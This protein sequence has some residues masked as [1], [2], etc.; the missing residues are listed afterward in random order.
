MTAGGKVRR[1][2]IYVDQAS[3]LGGSS[4]VL[5]GF[6]DRLFA[7]GVDPVIVCRRDSALR[8]RCEER[9]FV[10]HTANMPLLT[11]QAGPFQWFP[12]VWAIFSTTLSLTFLV[13]R[14]RASHL[15][16][17]GFIAAL[18]CAWAS[19]FSRTPC[20]WHMHDILGPSAT[21]KIFLRFAGWGADRIV[22]VSHAVKDRLVEFGIDQRKC[23]VVHNFIVPP[24]GGPSTNSLRTGL[25]FPAHAKIVGMVGNICE[26]KGQRIFLDA[27]REIEHRHPDTWYII[28]G[29]IFS[30]VDRPYKED[31]L[32]G[33]REYRLET[34]VLLT[35]FRDDAF[36]LIREMD[37]LVHPATQPEA[38]GLVLAEAMYHER[39]VIASRIGGIPEIVADSMSGILVPP[40]D[41]HALAQAM[42]TLLN[43]K[44]M[45]VRMGAAG[46]RILSGAYQIDL[47]LERLIGLYEETSK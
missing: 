3:V 47:F 34:K 44:E 37:V 28:V 45:R 24:P 8:I 39:P 25:V 30:E 31:I 36:W 11:K 6:L 40:R 7:S 10:V 43:N 9:G 16:A 38:F 22:C 13:K 17:N 2:V 14:Y 46:K 23:R 4:K 42:E 5:L 35:G 18:Y 19:V 27:I 21:N 41:A 12:Y 29:D 20:I 32:R 15:H 26:M 1:T 33:V